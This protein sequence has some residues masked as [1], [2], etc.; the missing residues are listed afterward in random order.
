MSLYGPSVTIPVYSVLAGVGIAITGVRFWVR[1]RFARIALGADDLFVVLG[2]IVAAA[3]TAMQFYNAVHGSGGDVIDPSA[4]AKA[5]VATHKI[6]WVMIVIEKP[7]FGFVKLSILLFY[8]RLFGIWPGFRRINNV[9]I[10][11]L[12]AWTLSFTVADVLLCGTHPELNWELDQMVAR[13]GCGDKGALLLAFAAT[14]VA[15]DVVLLVLPFFYLGNLQMTT[16]KKLSSGLVFFLGSASTIAS[17]LRLIFLSISLPLGRLTFGYSPPAGQK[18]PLVLQ[19][20]NP[21][22]WV[23]VELWL[24]IWAAN[25]PPCAPLLRSLHPYQLLTSL[26]KRTTSKVSSEPSTLEKKTSAGSSLSG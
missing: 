21:T 25:L 26:Y 5:I 13:R 4:H 8:R 6:D 1:T 12:V 16:Q 18:T 9:L 14:S 15:T 3:C 20:F 7:A 22:F 2:V 17:I 19:V 24:G 11:I 10:G 23:M